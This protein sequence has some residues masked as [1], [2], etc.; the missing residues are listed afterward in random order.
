MDVNISV[1]TSLILPPGLTEFC[2]NL[3]I[4][5]FPDLIQSCRG[6]TCIL[7]YI[8]HVFSMLFLSL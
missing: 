4:F 7:E 6:G 8:L 2:N 3:T 1:I 5:H